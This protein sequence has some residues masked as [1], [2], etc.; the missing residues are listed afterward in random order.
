MPSSKIKFGILVD[1][2]WGPSI[3]ICF[4]MTPK[5]M[6]GK[7]EAYVYINIIKWSITIGFIRQADYDEPSYED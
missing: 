3:G 7:R 4:S 6:D 1:K 2:T 5:D